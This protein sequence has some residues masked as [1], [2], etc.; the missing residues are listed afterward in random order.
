MSAQLPPWLAD[1]EW[2]EQAERFLDQLPEHHRRWFVGLVSLQLGWGGI[3]RV[4]ELFDVD[5]GTI[6]AGRNELR[7]GFED[8]PDGRV[9][10]PGGGRKP[11]EETHPEIEKGLLELVDTE[12]AGDPC[13]SRKW[14]RRSSRK[15]A[16]ALRNKGHKVS[17]E[18]VRRLLKKGGTPSGPIGSAS[19][20][21]RTQTGTRSLAT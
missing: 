2:R 16:A 9:R 18:T 19:P 13:S 21:R 6:R 1:T 4:C 7:A 14:T 8:R 15:L 10:S 11:L 5:P 20:D 17:H 3:Q 12:T